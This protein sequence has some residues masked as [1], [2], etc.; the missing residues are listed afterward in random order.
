MKNIITQTKMNPLSMFLAILV[1][2]LM[3]SSIALAQG[4]LIVIPRRVVFEG[5]KKTQELNLANTGTDTS[6]Y[7]I[8]VVEYRMRT[9]GSFESIEKADSGQYFADKNIR[10]FPRSVVLAPNEAQTIK[11]QVV[12]TTGMKTGEYRSHLFFRAVP[13]AK[14]LG[15]QNTDKSVK[16]LSVQLVPSF[17]VAIPVIIRLGITSRTVTVSNSSV[18]FTKKG[19][20]ELNVEFNRSGNI[21]SYGDITVDY[22]SPQGK[23][24]R[25]ATAKGFAIYTPNTKRDFKVNLNTSQNVNYHTGKLHIMYT[26]PPYAKPVRITES[27]LKLI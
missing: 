26:T 7:L 9:D 23:V 22:T 6:K 25:V 12:N 27:D 20:P 14:P 3:I 13:N 2:N 18:K 8:S 17:G 11:I 21:S 5:P 24:I 15:E 16:A 19:V 4:N 10:F 1:G